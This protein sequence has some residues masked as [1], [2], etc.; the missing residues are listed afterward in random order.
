MLHMT[1][2]THLK[3][4]PSFIALTG[5]YVRK[6][7]YEAQPHMQQAVPGAVHMGKNPLI[8]R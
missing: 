2:L 1:L 7:E 3:I 8:I 5:W 4:K 6:Y